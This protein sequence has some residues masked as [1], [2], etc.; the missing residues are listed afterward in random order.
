MPGYTKKRLG[1]TRPTRD[2]YR[3][4]PEYTQEKFCIGLDL[5]AIEFSMLRRKAV[6]AFVIEDVWKLAEVET[7]KRNINTKMA[8]GRIKAELMR[9]TFIR[10]RPDVV[11]PYWLDYM[12]DDFIQSVAVWMR[13]QQEKFPDTLIPG[14]HY[15]RHGFTWPHN[16]KPKKCALKFLTLEIIP[17]EMDERKER[18]HH[19]HISL[20]SL[21]SSQQRDEDDW[22]LEDLSFAR[23]W[24]KICRDRGIARDLKVYTLA[25]INHYWGQE[26]LLIYDNQT[27]KLKLYYL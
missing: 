10:N 12:L 16:K 1:Y 3:K 19:A 8:I 22:E 15:Y 9:H 21:V 7:K 2:W 24:N 23:L 11:Q 18:E 27:I 17:I 26:S 6:R 25:Y 5:S 4:T 13:K 14:R 20:R